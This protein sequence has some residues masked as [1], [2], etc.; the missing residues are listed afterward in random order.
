MPGAFSCRIPNLAFL[1]GGTG[2]ANQGIPHQDCKTFARDTALLSAGI[3][4][5]NLIP[6]TSVLPKE[7]HG[8]V[9][10]DI[11]PV[12][13]HFHHGA[14]LDVIV[15]EQG[16]DR[17]ESAALATGLGV[18]WAEDSTGIVGGFVAKYSQSYLSEIDEDIA[19]AEADLWLTKSLDHALKIRGLSKS[20]EYNIY[21]NWINIQDR[22][23]YCL[24][25]MGF[26]NFIFPDPIPLR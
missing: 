8:H 16:A 13:R 2:Q 6:Y 4:N 24:T 3:E 17:V 9:V 10:E 11:K 19:Y 15:A 22:F 21:V 7:L 12:K 14:V 18:G 1:T 20:G 23:G 26:L 25:A 5:F